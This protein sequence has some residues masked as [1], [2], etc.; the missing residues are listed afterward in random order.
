VLFAQIPESNCVEL[1]P[2]FNVSI[3]RCCMP[4]SRFTRI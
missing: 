1:L 2:L 4:D 3:D